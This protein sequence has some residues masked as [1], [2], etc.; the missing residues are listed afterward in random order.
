MIFKY[1]LISIL[2]LLSFFFSSAEVV[3]GSVNHLRLKKEIERKPTPINK[4]ALGFAE[5]FG[6]TVS[7]VLLGNALTNVAVSSLV[8]MITLSM[9]EVASS[10]G[11]AVVFLVLLIFCEIT[12]KTISLR[13]SFTLA[14]F[15]APLMKV[16]YYLFFPIVKVV[17]I[18]LD[19]MRNR[20]S[21]KRKAKEEADDTTDEELNV[22][23]DEI[24]KSGA[25]DEKKGELLHSAIDF[26][27][28]EAFECMTPRVDVFALDI[29]DNINQVLSDSDIFT[30]SRIPVYEGTVDNVIGIIPTKKL[31][32]A[33]LVKE[34][35]TP[36][37]IR[38]IM[39]KPMF[40][41]RSKLISDV[42]ED[43]K[44]NKRHMAIVVDEFGGTEG[45]ITLEDIIEE[46]V[47]DIWDETDEIEEQVT[48]IG[49]D[50]Y[51]IDGMMN[52]EDFFDLIDCSQEVDTDY[53]TV[54]GFCQDM[55]DRFAQVGD[56]FQFG[57]Y[58]FTI[59][60]ADQFTVNKVKVEKI[61]ASEE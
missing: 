5:N 60:E 56:S 10:I 26:A 6:D 40:V 28:T 38:K 48:K 58:L 13:Y 4:L 29:E 32:K 24:E 35:I 42:L 2:L 49:E 18:P 21:E 47:G 54:G 57:G 34:N 11:V 1:V 45:I 25:I 61:S 31:L 37:M 59:T 19:K 30:Y 53:T 27:D 8:A 22:M 7:I 23:V 20:L 43:F 16:F 51:L 55:L 44:T 33:I 36:D 52:I 12:P 15:Y 3:Y 14:H 17:T 46:I 50:M 41:H 39:V 9:G